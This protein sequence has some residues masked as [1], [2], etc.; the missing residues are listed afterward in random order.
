MYRQTLTGSLHGESQALQTPYK[1]DR[2]DC[3]P[4]IQWICERIRKE[5]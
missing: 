3:E 2:D 5:C 1:M 4:F